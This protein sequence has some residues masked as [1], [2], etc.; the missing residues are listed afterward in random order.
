VGGCDT[1]SVRIPPALAAK[2]TEQVLAALPPPP[3]R[4]LEVGFAGI[5]ATPLRLAGFTVEVLDEDPRAVERAGGVIATPTGRYDAV[6]APAEAD[7]TAVDAE[8]V[9]RL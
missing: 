5:H 4:V 6:V 2:L 7:L 8:R 3:A 1:A 9:I